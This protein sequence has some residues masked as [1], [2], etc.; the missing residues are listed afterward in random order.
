MFS[1]LVP[2]QLWQVF[3][4]V[5]SQTSSQVHCEVFARLKLPR[6]WLLLRITQNVIRKT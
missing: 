4:Q 2:S 1:G 6:T 5:R 3:A